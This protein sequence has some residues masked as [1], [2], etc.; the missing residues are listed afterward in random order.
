MNQP[1][2][3]QTQHIVVHTIGQSTFG[4]AGLI[5]SCLGWLT[6]GLLCIPGAAMSFLG[7]FSNKQKTHALVGLIVGFPGAIFFVMVGAAII[8]PFI[9]LGGL[10]ATTA[11]AQAARAQAE[12]MAANAGTPAQ[13][14]PLP[15]SNVTDEPQAEMI[16]AA[17]PDPGQPPIP[18]PVVVEPTNT[19]PVPAPEPPSRYRTFVDATGKFK[20]VAEIIAVKNNWVKLKKEDG[21]ELSMPIA[22]LST[23]DQEWIKANAK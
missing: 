18:E 14:E 15:E 17:L 5:F 12:A 1:Q 6:C 4:T 16:V 7:L 21:A 13:P 8:L 9:G 10:I 22:K 2:T 11:A 19:E 23:D 20:V 3:P